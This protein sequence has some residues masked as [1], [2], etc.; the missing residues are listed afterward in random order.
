MKAYDVY[1]PI[2]VA[3]PAEKVEGRWS[4]LETL[5]REQF[6]D[7]TQTT[8]YHQGA[9]NGADVNFKGELRAYSVRADEQDA[10]PFFKQ[11]KQQLAKMGLHDI[12]V[13]E[14]EATGRKGEPAG[15][16]I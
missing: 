11:F 7:Y 1:V 12:V 5:L 8:G 2:Q 6:G 14:K 3:R 10:R 9:W 4:W 13:V 16:R 15:E